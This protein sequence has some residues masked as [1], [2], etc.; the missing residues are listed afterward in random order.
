MPSP[1]LT[2]A[3][4]FLQARTVATFGGTESI[5]WPATEASNDYTVAVA[6][7]AGSL[8]AQSKELSGVL[9]LPTDGQVFHCTLADFPCEP[10]PDMSFV[11][12]PGDAS[13]VAASSK[14]FMIRSAKSF[15]EQIT[16]T[17]V[18]HGPAA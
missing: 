16:L 9:S 12:G 3:L 10:R 14:K 1:F 7:A 13:Y 4:S 18:Y 2:A 17:A 15:G 8:D 6:C 11:F 5:W